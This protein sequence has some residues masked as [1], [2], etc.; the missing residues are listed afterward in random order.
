ME[1][2]GSLA[3]PLAQLPPEAR[4]ESAAHRRLLRSMLRPWALA[5]TRQ[6]IADR[7]GEQLGLVSKALLALAEADPRV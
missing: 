1:T 5:V 6:A 7:F 4:P 2:A 3:E